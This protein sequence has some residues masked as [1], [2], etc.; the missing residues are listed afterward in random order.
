MPRWTRWRSTTASPHVLPEGERARLRGWL[1]RGAAPITIVSSAEAVGAI[2]EQVSRVADAT[3]WLQRGTAIAT[4]PRV[5][6]RLQTAGFATV[7]TCAPDDS[8]VIG[9]LESLQG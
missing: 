8:A 6:Q 2:L 4:H 9:K 7:E 5:A 1:A 3:E